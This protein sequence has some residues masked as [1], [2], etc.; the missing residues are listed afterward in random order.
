MVA[1]HANRAAVALGLGGVLWAAAALIG[2]ADGGDHFYVAESI[3]LAAQLAL[4]IGTIELWRARPHGSS[5]AGH[6]GFAIASLGRALFVLAE[7]LA[8]VTGEIQESVLPAAVTLTTLGMIIVGVAVVR[9]GILNGWR[10]W[11]FLAVGVYPLLFMIP[12]AAV[13]GEPPVASL[14]G[15]GAMFVLSGVAVSRSGSS[16]PTNT[17]AGR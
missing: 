11:V 9:A 4:L 5:R 16:A 12:F 17:A 6:V 3:W 8:L 14:I 7:V 2:G 1:S 10:R 15:W 13:M